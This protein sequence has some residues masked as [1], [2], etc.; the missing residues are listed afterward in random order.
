MRGD[1]RQV[2]L[3]T[4]GTR[5]CECLGRRATL[6]VPRAT[7]KPHAHLSPSRETIIPTRQNLLHALG[8]HTPHAKPRAA[9]RSPWHHRADHA[10]SHPR[11]N[12]EPTFTPCV[13]GQPQTTE[14]E[15]LP[16]RG[17]VLPQR[18]LQPAPGACH[19]EA[20]TTPRPSPCSSPSLQVHQPPAPCL[21][22]RVPGRVLPAC[23]QKGQA[24]QGQARL[25][26]PRQAWV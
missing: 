20:K 17:L 26:P 15:H 1:A 9:R 10:R 8:M 24:P 18:S 23:L 3:R 21:R 12:R 5:P 25:C 19:P 22:L 14:A 7:R 2:S 11:L 6:P 4:G 16:E 13:W